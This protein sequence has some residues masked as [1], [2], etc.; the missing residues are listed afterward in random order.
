M[1][2]IFH[3]G[4]RISSHHLFL[5]LGDWLIIVLAQLGAVSL[6]LG[7]DVGAEYLAHNW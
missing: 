7:F 6:R 3:R 5:T 4:A 2:F 1:V